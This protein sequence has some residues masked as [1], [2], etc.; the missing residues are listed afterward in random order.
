MKLD[1]D[2]VDFD[3][4]VAILCRAEIFFK[5]QGC[6][7]DVCEVNRDRH[8][9]NAKMARQAQQ[10]MWSARRSGEDRNEHGAEYAA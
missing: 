9:E 5:E 8:R 6:S 7:P 1:I 4:I 3:F 2:E 10:M